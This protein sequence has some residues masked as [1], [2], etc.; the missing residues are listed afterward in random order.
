MAQVSDPLPPH[1]SECDLAN[2]FADF[3][4]NKIQKIRLDLHS[5]EP[6]P[7]SVELQNAVCPHSL[8]GFTLV[9][10][11]EVSELIGKSPTKSCAL[12]PIPTWLLK[13]MH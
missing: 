7:L 6:S 3:F 8:S 9:T 4:C 11:K 2:S 12:D 13:K 10:E 1:E 5:E